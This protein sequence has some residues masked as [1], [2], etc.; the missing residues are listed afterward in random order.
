M[1]N[2]IVSI[3]KASG[4]GYC[5][6]KSS[7]TFASSDYNDFY[8]NTANSTSYIGY[9]SAT[10]QATLLN[11]QTATAQDANSISANPNFISDTNVHIA[12]NIPSPADGVGIA[13]PLVTNDIDGDL[14]NDPP[15]I[16]ADEF[17]YAPTN[18]DV[19][20]SAIGSYSASVVPGN[21]ITLSATAYNYGLL[22]QTF[23]VT[24]T[25]L[26]SSSSTVFTN[27]QNVTN[28]ATLTSEIV[29]FAPYTVGADNYTFTIET[30]LGTDTNSSNNSMSGAFIGEYFVNLYPFNASM[31]TGW[32]DANGTGASGEITGITQSSPE[33]RGFIKFDV[34]GIPAGSTVN[35]VTLGLYCSTGTISTATNPITLL[36]SDP[37]TAT[38]ST[39]F[40]EAGST[41]AILANMLWSPGPAPTWF[42]TPLTITDPLVLQGL[43]AQGWAGIGIRRGSTNSYTFDGYNGANPPYLKVYYTPP[44]CPSPQDAVT[45][46]SIQKSG[47]DVLLNWT[48]STGADNY[49]VYWDTVPG[50]T[51]NSMDVG[52]VLN[53][54]H[55][56][57]AVGSN[58][59]YTVTATC[60]TVSP[61]ASPNKKA[62]NAK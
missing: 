49:K 61:V 21:A 46:T 15:D 56:N 60:G 24:L 40:T 8:V 22:S 47:N 1:K 9:Y 13:I 18:N 53:W 41:T 20:I 5:V 37:Q 51:T 6:Y 54:T 11:W 55:T 39:L 26:N 31:A 59:F 62:N 35:S 4:T 28:L 2:N 58:F 57:G 17:D 3:N 19:G 30:T 12:T 52:D 27:T 32:S 44:A 45:V 25:I 34:S 16:G 23:G 7:G 42:T 48:A 29:T 10:A 43:I 33:H 38:F 36:T 14:R 50:G